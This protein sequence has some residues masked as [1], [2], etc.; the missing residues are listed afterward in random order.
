MA[1]PGRW[2]GQGLALL[3]GAAFA[4][5]VGHGEA[6]ARLYWWEALGGAQPPSADSLAQAPNWL[7]SAEAGR[8]IAGVLALLVFAVLA[9][10][11]GRQ[12]LGLFCWTAGLCLGAALVA[13]GLLGE[14]GSD[15]ERPEPVW[16]W[17]QPLWLTAGSQLL[18]AL[19]LAAG[20][21]WLMSNKWRR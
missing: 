2:Q 8:Q 13:Q 11:S 17:P 19:V 21:L 1:S 3:G 6:V 14:R 9:G 16:L 4:L 12:R 20:G 7:L 15:F 5:A 18:L 10:R